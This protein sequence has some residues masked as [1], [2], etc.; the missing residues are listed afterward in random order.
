VTDKID[1]FI[2]V[3]ENLTTSG[4]PGLHITLAVPAIGLSGNA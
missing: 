3:E 2:E 4:L 1:I